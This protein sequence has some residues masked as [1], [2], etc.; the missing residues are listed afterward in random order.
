MKSRQKSDDIEFGLKLLTAI[1]EPGVRYDAAEIAAWCGCSRQAIEQLESKALARA[2][3]E[4]VKRGFQELN[5]PEPHDP[6][7]PV[8]APFLTGL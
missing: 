7:D 2:R 3:Q 8:S 5:M 4:F 6:A 1:A